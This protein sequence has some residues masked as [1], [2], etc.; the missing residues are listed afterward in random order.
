MSLEKK[1]KVISH[2]INLVVLS[3]SIKVKLKFDKSP[4]IKVKRTKLAVASV[5]LKRGKM[6][7]KERKTLR[8]TNPY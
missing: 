6:S 5:N 3:T 1:K 4:Q 2:L 7:S 8:Y